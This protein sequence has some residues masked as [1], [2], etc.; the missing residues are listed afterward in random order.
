MITLEYFCTSCLPEEPAPHICIKKTIQN[1]PK[2]LRIMK[3]FYPRLRVFENRIPRQIF[4]PKRDENGEWK[5]LH[6]EE[7]H[8]L[9][10]SLNIVRVIKSRRLR[11][12]G[13]VVRMEEVRSAFKN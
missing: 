1:I 5:S 10:R 11:W 6:H 7:L 12:A 9:Y 13:H 2:I 3:V 8:S 4:G